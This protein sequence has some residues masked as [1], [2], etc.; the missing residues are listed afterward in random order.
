MAKKLYT[1]K[2]SSIHNRGLF[3]KEAIKKG[4]RVIQY[5]GE[6]ISKQESAKR[7]LEWEENAKKSGKGLVYI[8]ELDDDWDLDGRVGKNPARYI[9]H[10]CEGNCEAVNDGGE[11]WI[12]SV[13]DIVMGEELNY[14]YGYDMEHFLDHP[15]RCG[16]KKCIGYIVRE[17][18]RLKVKKLL[19]KRK[20]KKPAKK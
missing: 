15:C 13:A 2:D 1:V 9:N 12:Y 4:S 7:A 19:K 16:S 20:K 3:A 10:S 17:D 8:F 5:K 14:D 6:K 18:Q 11:I